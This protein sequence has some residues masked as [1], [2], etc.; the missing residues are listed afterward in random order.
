MELE[1]VL[2]TGNEDI[3][4]GLQK[5]IETVMNDTYHRFE[6]SKDFEQLLKNISL[7]E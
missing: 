1:K 4:D 6:R 3:F 2:H 5:Q 7:T